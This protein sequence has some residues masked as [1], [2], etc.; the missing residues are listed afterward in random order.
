MA[1][2]RDELDA[3][4]S[5]GSISQ[6]RRSRPARVRCPPGP[7]RSRRSP[8]HGDSGSRHNGRRYHFLLSTFYFL[9]SLSTFY[10][11]P[12]SRPMP[13]PRCGAAMT[14]ETRAGRLGAPIIIDLCLPCQVLWFDTHESLQ[15]SPGAVK[16]AVPRHWGTGAG[17]ASAGGPRS[18]LSPLRH[19][20]R[21]DTR[22]ATQHEIPISALSIGITDG[23]SPLS[24]SCGR[25]ISS[26]RC[27]RSK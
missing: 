20:P 26:A 22:P 11:L 7:M 4:R 18:A 16:T 19:S 13:C 9:L 2:T 10:L 3:V 15:L 12:S 6:R 21:P 14:R 1:R 25:R 8:D 23:S 17:S 5:P 27:P 24:I